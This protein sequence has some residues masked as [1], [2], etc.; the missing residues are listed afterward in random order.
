MTENDV[1]LF[2]VVAVLA[3][4]IFVAKSRGW[5]GRLWLF[6]MMQLANL[7]AGSFM[8]IKG[9]PEFKDDLEIVNIMIGLLF[10]YHVI[11]NNGRW[12]RYRRSLQASKP[13]VN[14]EKE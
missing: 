8:I 2:S 14:T 10:F 9:I 6:A 11:Q 13:S 12:Q 1:I 7:G 5:E 4:N 3:I